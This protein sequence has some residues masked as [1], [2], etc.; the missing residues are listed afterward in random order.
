M[1][2]SVPYKSLLAARWIAHPFRLLFPAQNAK[3]ALPFDRDRVVRSGVFSWCW[4]PDDT[5]VNDGSIVEER[6]LKVKAGRGL[7]GMGYQEQGKAL[8]MEG[9]AAFV[10]G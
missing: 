3:T 8:R 5:P 10:D 2:Y 4:S 6:R 7:E 9:F 1:L